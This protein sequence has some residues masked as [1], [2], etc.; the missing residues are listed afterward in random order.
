[1]DNAGL[2]GDPLQLEA[3]D[4]AI[5]ISDLEQQVEAL[6]GGVVHTTDACPPELHEAF[7]RNIIHIETRPLECRFNML[8]EAGVELPAAETLNDSDLHAK[9][10]EVVHS[11]AARD[12]YLERTDHLSDRELYE[13]LWSDLLREAV[14]ILPAGSG[15]VCHLDILGGCSEEDLQLSLRYYDDEKQR[16]RWAKDFPEDVIPPHEDPPFQRDRLLPK[17]VFPDFAGG[18]EDSNESE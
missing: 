16:E 9:L 1:M 15:W 3:V 6:G 2:P 17:P 13:R 7:L 10:W 8:V 18:D 4:R 5:R 12:V 11:L 14:P